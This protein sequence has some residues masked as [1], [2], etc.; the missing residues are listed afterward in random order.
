MDALI[1]DRLSRSAGQYA[2]MAES[3]LSQPDKLPRSFQNEKLITGNSSWWCSGFMPGTLWYLYE[4][5]NDAKFLEYARTYTARIEKEQYNTGTHD[6]GF[7]IYCSYGNALRLTGDRACIPVMMTGAESL[8]TRYDP[9]I[10]CIRSWNSN[11]KWQFPVI[12]DNMMNLDFLLWAS[13]HSGDPRFRD[14]C[15]S[16]A[17]K[18]V[19]NHF[20]EDYSSYH[21]VSYDTVTGLPEKKNTHQGYSDQSAWARG[22]AWGL[23]GYVMMY[24]ETNRQAYLD[25]AKG[26]AGFLI[27]HPNL[28]ADKIPYWDFDAPDIPEAKRDASAA[29]IMAS[30][31]LELSRYVDRELADEYIRVAE[32][33]L[34]TLSSPEYFAEK[35]SNGYFILKHST[36]H[37]P[38]NSEVDVP[39]TYAD[40]YYVEALLRYKNRILKS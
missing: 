19:R 23:Y 4:Y 39:L 36:G 10:G 6:L 31:L 40:Y 5:T 11:A 14:I 25:Q 22:Q 20:R 27:H 3:L 15:I 17:D 24:R 35:G 2:L 12:I 13:K 34:R 21:V 26:I 18:T 30:A 32:T 8:A 1:A 33:Q 9:L 7:M 16:H 38:G 28:P 29:A 37:L